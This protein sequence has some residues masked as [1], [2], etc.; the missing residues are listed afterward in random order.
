MKE[1]DFIVLAKQYFGE[2]LEP[3]GFN[4]EKS[5]KCTFYKTLEKIC[6]IIKPVLSKDGTWFNIYV[7]ATSP[8]I[9]YKFEKDFPDRL[10]IP[11]D[12]CSH[13]HPRRGVSFRDHRY[14]CRSEEGFIRNFNKDAKPALIENAIPY[15]EPIKGIKDMIPLIKNKYYFS[16]ALYVTGNTGKATPLISEELERLSII[17]P[18]TDEVEQSIS[19]LNS[20]LSTDYVCS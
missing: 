8:L 3:F 2:V 13:L 4:C 12:V 6:L 11:M 7:Y 1:K 14:R 17:Y 5:N 19:F 20:V 9:D 10:A 15:L 16:V 18:Q